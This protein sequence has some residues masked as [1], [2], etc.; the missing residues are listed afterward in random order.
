MRQCDFEVGRPFT[1]EELARVQMEM[2][3]IVEEDLPIE[4]HEMSKGDARALLIRRGEVLKLELLEEID[5]PTVILYS[6]GEHID[7]CRG[8]HASSTGRVSDA[9]LTGLAAANWRDD[10]Y[11][12]TLNRIYGAVAFAD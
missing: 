6:Q 3:R 10:P 7:L 1:R 9:R 2:A 12:E 4:R 5:G 11:A 8:P